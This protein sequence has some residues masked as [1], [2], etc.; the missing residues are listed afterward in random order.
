VSAVGLKKK[1]ERAKPFQNLS[2]I[3]Y[4]KLRMHPQEFLPLVLDAHQVAKSL[5]L[6]LLFQP[7]VQLTQRPPPMRFTDVQAQQP[8]T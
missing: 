5:G 7:R 2:S 1:S 4:L 8:E 6:V 3:L